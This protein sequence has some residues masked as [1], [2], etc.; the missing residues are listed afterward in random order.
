MA[1][2]GKML[3]NINSALGS[4]SPQQRAMLLRAAASNSRS[5]VGAQGLAAQAREMMQAEQQRLQQEAQM[6]QLMQQQQFRGEQGRLDRQFRGEQGVLNRSNS[7]ALSEAERGSREKIASDRN[8]AMAPYY[9]ALINAAQYKNPFFGMDQLP[10]DE[11]E[12]KA[13]GWFDKMFGGEEE[14]KKKGK[15]EKGMFEALL[16]ALSAGGMGSAPAPQPPAPD[17]PRAPW[18]PPPTPPPGSEIMPN[19]FSGPGSMLDSVREYI[20]RRDEQLRKAR[21]LQ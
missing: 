12:G 19:I 10:A 3:G 20:R 13:E 8:A 16:Q 2:I 18:A 6:K 11:S 9:Q 21:G 17:A 1:G 7:A 4:L 15:D 14:E 5:A